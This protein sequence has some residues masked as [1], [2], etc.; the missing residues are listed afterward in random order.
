M[1]EYDPTRVTT[2]DGVENDIRII[3]V[4]TKSQLRKF[5]NLPNVMY[6]D[7]PQFVP[8]TYGDDISDWDKRG[9]PAYE[10]CETVC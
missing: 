7:V 3:E 4:R 10:Y 1:K 6:R 5:V 2:G 8:A 9:N